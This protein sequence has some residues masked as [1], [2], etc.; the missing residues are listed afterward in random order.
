MGKKKKRKQ[1]RTEAVKT[2]AALISSIAALIAA[3]AALLKD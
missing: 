2:I 1:A 3:I